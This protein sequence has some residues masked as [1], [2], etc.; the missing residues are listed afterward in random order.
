MLTP[1]VN[2]LLSL[3]V[4]FHANSTAISIQLDSANTKPNPNNNLNYHNNNNNNEHGST[5]TT[6]TASIAGVTLQDNNTGKSFQVTADYYL[7]AV[8]IDSKQA[9]IH[10]TTSLD[11]ISYLWYLSSY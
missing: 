1:W 3:G 7:F 6:S 4:Q 8:P 11:L 2:Y 10:P 9:Y 5:A